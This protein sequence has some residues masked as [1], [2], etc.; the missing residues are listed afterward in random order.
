MKDHALCFGFSHWF[1]DWDFLVLDRQFFH[2]RSPRSPHKNS[3]FNKPEPFL[4]RYFS[5][6]FK[7][8]GGG[9]QQSDDVISVPGKWL[10]SS[11]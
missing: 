11:T 6:P 7:L 4:T 8:T 9:K 1:F 3:A 5:C 2:E 10:R